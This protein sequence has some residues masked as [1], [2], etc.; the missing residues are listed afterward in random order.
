[1]KNLLSIIILMFTAINLYSFALPVLSSQ[2]KKEKAMAIGKTILSE[3]PDIQEF[4]KHTSGDSYKERVLTFLY[5]ENCLDN[6]KIT[7][8]D[9]RVFYL[10][11]EVTEDCVLECAL[12]TENGEYSN[13]FLGTDLEMS[14]DIELGKVDFEKIGSMDLKGQGIMTAIIN[15]IKPIIFDG[16]T[17]NLMVVNKP[18]VKAMASIKEPFS[19]KL[20]KDFFCAYTVI[21]KMLSR[22]G[23]NEFIFKAFPREWKDFKYVELNELTTEETRNDFSEQIKDMKGF[24]VMAIK[25]PELVLK[26]EL[27]LKKDDYLKIIQSQKPSFRIEEIL[28]ST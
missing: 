24:F 5:M 17:L 14:V 21:G 4:L 28:K 12:K 9:G 27:E 22:L 11:V 15:E 8:K 25:K 20:Y 13:A 6:K 2:S 26:G 19:E 10:A 18:T 23:F 1:M 16:M 7:L 3:R